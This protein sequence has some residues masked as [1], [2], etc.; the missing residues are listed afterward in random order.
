MTDEYIS[1]RKQ[2]ENEL[3][4][5]RE[6]FEHHMAR[7]DRGETTRELAIAALKLEIEVAYE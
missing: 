4:H 3:A 2:R 1:P 6:R 5:I 7:E